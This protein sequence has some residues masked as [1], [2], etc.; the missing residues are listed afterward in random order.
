MRALILVLVLLAGGTALARKPGDFVA[1]R[2]MTSEELEAAKAR[3]KNKIDSFG[4]DVPQESKPFPW[5]A[6]LL[7]GLAMLAVTPFAIRA[8]RQ[9]SGELGGNKAFGAARPEGAEGEE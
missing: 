8:Y 6:V 3:S 7:M 9:T 4:R 1:P 2:E 5:R